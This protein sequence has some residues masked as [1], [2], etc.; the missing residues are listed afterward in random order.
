MSHTDATAWKE[1]VEEKIDEVVKACHRVIV[2]ECND[3]S[4]RQE[5]HKGLGAEAQAVLNGLAAM[6]SAAKLPAEIEDLRTRIDRFVANRNPGSFPALNASIERLKTISENSEKLLSFHDIFESYKSDEELGELAAHLIATLE[7]V[8]DEGEVSIKARLDHDLRKLLDHLKGKK[9]HSLLELGA[10]AE[11]VGRVALEAAAQY[12]DVPGGAL[13][14]DVSKAA[15]AVQKRVG[16]KYREG[17][18]EF[19]RLL[20]VKSAG[21][22]LHDLPELNDTNVLLIGGEGSEIPLKKAP[23]P[24]A[25]EEPQN[26][27][28]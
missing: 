6:F 13:L 15:W 17:Q 12:F 25:S 8:I 9:N 11:I 7:K 24:D 1:N 18:N 28:P 16:E 20:E 14:M 4:Q 27:S 21:I 23:S 19:V 10:L 5:Y 26:S 2:A 3:P 22:S